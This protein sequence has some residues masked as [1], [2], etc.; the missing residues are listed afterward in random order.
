MSQKVIQTGN[1]LAVTIPSDFVKAGGIRV[2]DLVKVSLKPEKG[3]MV[4]Q[5]SGIQQLLLGEAFTNKRK[6]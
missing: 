3:L 5:F 2:G 4:C 6:K 1:S